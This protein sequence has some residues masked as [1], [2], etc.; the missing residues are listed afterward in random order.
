MVTRAEMRP[1][2]SVA[3]CAHATCYH[4]PFFG[5]SFFFLWPFFGSSVGFLAIFRLE[6]NVE[7][8]VDLNVDLDVELN[9]ELYVVLYCRRLGGQCVSIPNRE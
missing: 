9:V 4:W 2:V 8:N 5:L 6:L 3:L 7:F 1:I